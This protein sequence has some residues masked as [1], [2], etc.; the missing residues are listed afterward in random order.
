MKSTPVRYVAPTDLVWFAF[1]SDNNLMIAPSIVTFK[2]A[3]DPDR[4]RNMIQERMVDRHF[5]FRS[6]IVETG[7]WLKPMAWEEDPNFDIEYHMPQ[8]TLDVCEHEEPLNALQRFASEIISTPL[9]KNYPLWQFHLIDLAVDGKPQTA[10][11]V[12]IH[13]CV[14]DGISLMQLLIAVAEE[15]RENSFAGVSPTVA[16]LEGSSRSN[17]KKLA[18]LRKS[19][20]KPVVFFKALATR[21]LRSIVITFA[22][23]RLLTM[24]RDPQT[25]L[26]GPLCH[27]KE[28]VWSNPIPLHQLKEIAKRYGCK[29]NDVMIA[30]LTSSLRSYLA[31]KKALTEKLEFRAVVPFNLRPL[32]FDKDKS[33]RLGNNFGLIFLKLPLF[34]KD[35]GQRL[36]EIHR[37]M[38]KIKRAPDAIIAFQVMG[39][40]GIL[41]R[42]FSDRFINMMGR[43]STLVAT[44]VPGP[45]HTLYMAGSE[46][47]SVIIWAPQ[48][49]KLGMGYSLLSY[50]GYVSAGIMV[51]SGLIPDP[52]RLLNFFLKELDTFL[53][54]GNVQESHAPGSVS[55]LLSTVS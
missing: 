43:K 3:L 4:F 17:A 38:A 31:E 27:T 28:V 53:K 42:R 23:L 55:P 20:R 51:D 19:I 25:P 41:P 45:R 44:N 24:P 12:R 16:L 32:D 49:G 36:K 33:V 35:R 50:A 46:I 14:A 18:S 5:R 37:R 34:I 9:D 54:E 22:V 10:V 15:I 40:L 39:L 6:K 52:Q 7:R 48:S 47:E 21:M 8:V 30:L 29:V 26:K 11:I 13:H 2:E 1:E